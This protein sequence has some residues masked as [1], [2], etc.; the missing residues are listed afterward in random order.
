M[1]DKELGKIGKYHNLN[2]SFISESLALRFDIPS[3]YD[4][5][6]GKPKST[7]RH[8][9]LLPHEIVASFYTFKSG[10]LFG[11]LTGPPGDPRWQICRP[12]NISICI[13]INIYL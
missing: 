6:Q 4:D 5:A 11:R 13:Y 2:P 1:D 3:R 8:A 10:R 9:M 7:T 12:T